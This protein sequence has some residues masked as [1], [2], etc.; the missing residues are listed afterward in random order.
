MNPADPLFLDVVDKLKETVQEGRSIE[1]AQVQLIGLDD[2][3]RAAGADWDK[4]KHR[5]RS[6]SLSFLQGCLDIRDIVIPAG[7]GFLVIFAEDEGRDLMRERQSICEA[8]NAFYLG[9]EG[10]RSLRS[11]VSRA[12]LDASAV[13]AM[14]PGQEDRAKAK[15]APRIAPIAAAPKGAEREIVFAPV[16]SSERQA[17]TT[18]FA[19]P[20]YREGGLLRYGYDPAYRAGAPG[21]RGRFADFDL[22]LLEASIDAAQQ[23]LAEDRR[24]LVGFSVHSGTMQDWRTRR[25]ILQRL[26]AAPEAVRKYLMPRIGEIESGTPLMTIAEWASSFRATTPRVGVELRPCERTLDGLE[27]TGVWSV[28]CFLPVWSTLSAPA[29]DRC[30]QL[31]ARWAARLH[32][33]GLKCFADNLGDPDVL[34]GAADVGVDFITSP[35]VWPILPAPAG[36]APFARSR[37]R[38]AF[39]LPQC[40]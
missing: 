7:D 37:V 24:C 20:G 11:S 14:F 3:R 8:L 27:T 15:A 22:R 32:R 4:I 35:A 10:M 28:G 12:T 29:R 16:W 1:A 18:Y 26:A 19:A 13:S 25:L 9:E 23:C 31:L 2:I 17:V 34:L 33:Q 39:H 30:I 21:Q 5:V 40:A 6:N 36:V 38:E